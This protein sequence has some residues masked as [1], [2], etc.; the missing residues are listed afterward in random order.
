MRLRWNDGADAEGLVDYGV[1]DREVCQGS[2]V[3][4]VATK[5]FDLVLKLSVDFLVSS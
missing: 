4:V 3:D 1:Q 5:L 2:G